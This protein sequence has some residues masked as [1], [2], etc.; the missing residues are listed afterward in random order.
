MTYSVSFTKQA[1]KELE[2]I[3][4]PFYSKIKLAI[5]N[6]KDNPRPYGCIKLKGRDSYRIRVGDYRVIY[7]IF[8]KDLVVDIIKVGNRGE[9]YE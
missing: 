6:L 3:S 8:D 4:E 2:K 1:Y 7:D 9:V 5:Q